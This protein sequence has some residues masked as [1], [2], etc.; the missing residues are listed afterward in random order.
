MEIRRAR[1]EDLPAVAQTLHEAFRHD[2]IS[3]WVFPHDDLRETYHPTLMRMFLDAAFG[4]GEVYLTPGAHG[5]ALWW[6]IAPDEHDESG[7]ASTIAAAVGPS[8]PR[9]LALDK[10]FSARHPSGVAHLDLHFLA[11][12]PGHQGHG[13][14][15]AL[16]EHRL[17]LADKDGLP[18]YLESSS[19]RSA[20]L[21]ARLGFAHQEPLTLPEAG[22]PIFPM[23]RG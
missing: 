17:T 2:P 8:G 6:S 5:V 9:V 16:L 4:G 20:A 1:S 11:V 13:I 22:P 12:R 7:L 21:Y 18:A 10:A 3:T 15:T 23:W 14:G 19:V